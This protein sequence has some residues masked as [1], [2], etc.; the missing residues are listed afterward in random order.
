MRTHTGER[1]HQCLFP[2]CGKSFLRKD[3]LT[4][5]QYSHKQERPFPCTFPQCDKSFATAQRL[6]RHRNL[7]NKP[8]PF[9]C[10]LCDQSFLKPHAL[11]L[12]RATHAHS[13]PL[14]Y[15][16]D[17]PNCQSV[18]SQHV[19]LQR[20]KAKC[21][22]RTFTCVADN[23]TAP[24]FQTY[25]DLTRH[26][27]IVHEPR[28]VYQ[29][30]LCA[31]QVRSAPALARHVAACETG[32]LVR[33]HRCGYPHCGAVYSS[34]GNLGTHI[35]SKHTNPGGFFC[36]SC[37]R[38]FSLKSSMERHKRTVH[39]PSSNHSC[40]VCHTT[41]L[42]ADHLR[43][44]LAERHNVQQ[45]TSP[46][47]L[48]LNKPPPLILESPLHPSSVEHPYVP[49]RNP[50][51]VINHAN[52]RPDANHPYAESDKLVNISEP[53][54]PGMSLRV[55]AQS[56]S[57]S[58]TQQHKPQLIGERP[59]VTQCPPISDLR[60]S[61]A[62]DSSIFDQRM[63]HERSV[64]HAVNPLQP[65]SGFSATEGSPA[66][67]RRCLNP[68][69]TVPSSAAL[70]GKLSENV[71][72]INPNDVNSYGPF[73]NS[74]RVWENN[75]QSSLRLPGQ[76]DKH[77]NTRHNV[78]PSAI[79]TLFPRDES[80]PT[81]SPQS[82]VM[83]YGR[84]QGMEETN[85]I[86]QAVSDQRHNCS[87]QETRV[88]ADCSEAN[89]HAYRTQPP[90]T[91]GFTNQSKTPPL[92]LGSP[93]P[94]L[95]DLFVAGSAP[96]GTYYGDSRDIAPQDSVPVNHNVPQEATPQ[97]GPLAEESREPA[98]PPLVN[99]SEERSADRVGFRVMTARA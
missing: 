88:Q 97:R 39:P 10:D 54:P 90:A 69:V 35:R 5:H 12:H 51:P 1:P 24:A 77:E 53:P 57:F 25:S 68:D 60:M 45:T 87:Q 71:M 84:V 47:P 13:E 43:T 30:K 44:H 76:T 49:D 86:R 61:L 67:K 46:T 15:A 82:C 70:E 79:S 92:A 95:Q 48:I 83:D 8:H 64:E 59:N 2:L 40:F 52:A 41:L 3:H 66:A 56:A 27:R 96:A 6:S 55:P 94:T 89:E 14:T 75:A 93:N 26:V 58:I 32:S 74:L 72:H 33:E 18:F 85:S 28:P 50:Q 63:R 20:H 65:N 78:S 34:S 16:C 42:S 81:V 62:M 29:C 17:A 11:D 36:D 99:N 7:H 9:K 80:T 73:H 4:R 38:R 37:D 21:H 23:C 31:R 22:T 19:R 91:C 98:P